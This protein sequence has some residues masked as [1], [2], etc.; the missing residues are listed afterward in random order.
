MA[1]ITLMS[2]STERGQLSS[3]QIKKSIDEMQKS[4]ANTLKRKSLT[5]I[6]SVSQ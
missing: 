4:A 6:L 5:S 3:L 2:P 1:L